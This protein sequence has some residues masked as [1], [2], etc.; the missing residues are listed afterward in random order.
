MRCKIYIYPWNV[1]YVDCM[2]MIRINLN[3]IISYGNRLEVRFEIF[4]IF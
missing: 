3:A 1:E 2:E 4:R